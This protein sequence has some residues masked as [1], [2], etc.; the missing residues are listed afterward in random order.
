LCQ[1][2]L[3]I[4]DEAH[5]TRQRL[6]KISDLTKEEPEIKGYHDV[7]NLLRESIDE[8][9]L[10]FPEDRA[11]SLVLPRDDLPVFLEES[12]FKRAMVSLLLYGADFREG[13]KIRPI[14]CRARPILPPENGN[15]SVWGP[16]PSSGGV[17]VS[18]RIWRIPTVPMEKFF[19]TFWDPESHKIGFL[20]HKRFIEENN[21][22]MVFRTFPEKNK[23][24]VHLFFPFP[25]TF[26][27]IP[28]P[29][30]Q[31]LP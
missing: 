12:K 5:R 21:G 16:T 22:R 7:K 18:F 31:A 28:P 8:F 17:E 2:L 3:E 20:G 6:Q 27:E 10:L 15:T 24:D 1:Y 19:N 13:R 4:R 29:T 26:S 23:I 9:N 14:L 25:K 11:V 30:P